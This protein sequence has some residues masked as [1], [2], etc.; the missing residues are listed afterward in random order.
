[1]QKLYVVKDGIKGVGYVCK[2]GEQVKNTNFYLL[3]YVF[4]SNVG[5]IERKTFNNWLLYT[6][7]GNPTYFEERYS[8][9]STFEE[10]ILKLKELCGSTTVEVCDSVDV[11][12][13]R[14]QLSVK[15]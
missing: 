11:P 5:K 1:M 7:I 13:L 9:F 15:K 12:Y 3:T 2:N 8:P 10:C 14:D 6:S 4:K